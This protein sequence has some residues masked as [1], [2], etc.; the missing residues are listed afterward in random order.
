MS[1]KP[2]EQSDYGFHLPSWEQ[3]K[4]DLFVAAGV[5]ALSLSIGAGVV[6][7]LTGGG[8]GTTP[9]QKSSAEM[10]EKLLSTMKPEEFSPFPNIET[11]L[12]PKEGE[13]IDVF[14]GQ[15]GPDLRKK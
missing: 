15:A 2:S 10:A 6:Y 4:S 9:R 7:V 12:K 1:N 5:A 8:K 3:L 13:P 14:P 11:P